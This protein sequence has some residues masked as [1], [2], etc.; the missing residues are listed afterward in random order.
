MVRRIGLV[1]VAAGMECWQF[2]AAGLNQLRGGA[3]AKPESG[4]SGALKQ[5]IRLRKT[6]Q[7]PVTW[8]RLTQAFMTS[9]TAIS[10]GLS[11]A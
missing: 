11:V 5:L 9:Q 10:D 2:C 7:A 1:G 4:K 6:T 8:T 3:L